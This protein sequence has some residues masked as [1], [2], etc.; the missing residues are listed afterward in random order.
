[1]RTFLSHIHDAFHEPDKRIYRVV[2]AG[3]WALI[4]L[5][6]ILLVAE[7]FVPEDGPVYEAVQRIDRLILVLFAVE[8][9]LRVVSFR[10]PALEMF[11]RA[12]IGRLKAHLFSRIG[13][14]LS[15][16]MLVD[17][18]AVLAVFP[19]L[20]GLRALRLLRLL[21]QSYRRIAICRKSRN[22]RKTRRQENTPKPMSSTFAMP[23]K[24]VP[25]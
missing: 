15:P 18:L 17:L 25:R 9:L 2:Q 8:I 16:I 20:R 6:I 4:L 10:P 24:N 7:A 19:E 21:R 22:S 12:P 5:S 13:F 3:V 23:L 11:K 14:L 1:M